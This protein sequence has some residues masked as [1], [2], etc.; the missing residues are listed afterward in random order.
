MIHKAFRILET[1]SSKKANTIDGIS[2]TTNIPRS[3]VHRI[4]RILTDEG[5]VA[6]KKKV[7]YVLTPKL[8]SLVLNG[9]PEREI[10]DIAV[11]IMRVLAEKTKETVS[12]NTICGHE[13]VCI[14]RVEGDQPITRKIPIGS[15]GSLFKGSAGKIIASGLSQKEIQKMIEIYIA[16]GELKEEEIPEI[17]QQIQTVR[18]QGYAISI[19]ERIK[20]SASIA[21]PIKDITGNVTAALSLSTIESRFG[22]ENKQRFLNLL[23]E[24]SRQ[25]SASQVAL[26]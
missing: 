15:K 24:A 16:N 14:Y 17:L 10:M 9:I 7:G 2:S 13:R 12:L 3:T 1:L 21:V 4:L 25:I 5:I 11:P 20:N 6:N 18:E 22:E 23:L 8:L 26:L 19:G